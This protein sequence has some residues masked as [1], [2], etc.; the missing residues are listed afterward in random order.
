MRT[1]LIVVVLLAAAFR[2][3]A[4]QKYWVYFT[5][6]DRPV[7]GVAYVSEKTRLNRQL[8]GLPEHQAS[9]LPVRRAY[10]E[11][12]AAHARVAGQ[13][14][15][16]NAVSVL[17]DRAGVE[18]IRQLP[19]VQ[20]VHGVQAHIG[21][22]GTGGVIN[23]DAYALQQVNAG[24]L[25]NTG[26]TGKGVTIGIVDGRFAEATENPSLRHVFGAGR[27]LGTRD[28]TGTGSSNFYQSTGN[29]FDQHGTAVW[30][31]IA[32]HDPEQRVQ[33]GLAVDAS[34]YLARTEVS[35]KE[36][37]GEED[38]WIAAIEWMDSLGV[39]LVN[40]SLGYSLD[41][42]DPAENYSPRDMDGKTSILARAAGVAVREKGMILVSSA[43]ND[44]DNQQ[45]QVVSTP[46]DAEGVLSVGST[47][48][49]GLKTSSSAVGPAALAY[50]KPDVTCFSEGGTSFSAPVITGLIAC[51][52]EKHAT[53]SNRQVAEALR[54]AGH[55]YP[56]GNNYLGYGVPD[57]GRLLRLCA[58]PGTDLK[59]SATLRVKGASHTLYRLKAPV[60]LFHKKDEW[61][62]V[63]Q[64]SRQP[65]AAGSLVVER[66][67]GVRRTTLD[68]QSQVL[69]ICWE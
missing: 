44:G 53:L 52:L 32:G 11:R 51:L 43:G 31:L 57:A 14:R 23:L 67:A 5:G 17:A 1:S 55:L 12:V 28:F 40:S 61:V 24:V 59:R 20:A 7:P 49:G 37:R 36:F 2:L 30:Q 13:S 16:L 66:P 58:A 8:L 25:K 62:V 10:V 22:A 47:D 46:A 65:S 18:A 34:F 45:W 56:Y 41:F 21:K 35:D 64:E 3:P 33:N 27:V 60:T 63:K 19:F 42:D 50:L 69:E 6:K 54:Q 48:R 39:R 26:L 4:Q 15:W 9:D 38:Y 29:G 68:L